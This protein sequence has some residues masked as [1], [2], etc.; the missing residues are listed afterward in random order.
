MPSVSS[1]SPNNTFY[2]TF[3]GTQLAGKSLYF[4]LFSVFKQT[5]HDCNNGVREDL[6]EALITLVLSGFLPG[7][8]N[9]KGLS[10]P[11]YWQWNQTIGDLKPRPGR[12]GTWG[13]IKTDGFGI[14]EQMQMAQGLNVTVVL[15]VWAGIYLD[16]KTVP[17]SELQ[18]YVD[19][20][21]NLLGFLTVRP[22]TR[23]L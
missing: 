8:N 4:N 10:S 5:C 2:F 11:Y 17:K 15:G 1:T 7:G 20:A 14:L 22:L 13:D 3:N 23:R 19:E 16:G 12:L 21:M 9:M 6:A 18:A